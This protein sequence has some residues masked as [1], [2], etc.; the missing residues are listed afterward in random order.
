MLDEVKRVALAI[1]TAKQGE[2]VQLPS[3][4]QVR[5]GVYLLPRVWRHETFYV[6]NPLSLQQ[7]ASYFDLVILIPFNNAEETQLVTSLV[8]NRNYYL[9]VLDGDPASVWVDYNPEIVSSWLALFREADHVLV[10]CAEYLPWLRQWI[11]HDRVSYFPEPNYFATLR[12]SRR[13]QFKKWVHHFVSKQTKLKVICPFNPA[14][15]FN[16]ARQPFLSLMAFN[17]IYQNLKE[18]K[19]E[20]LIL[21]DNRTVDYLESWNLNWIQVAKPESIHDL[22][23]IY[24]AAF[25]MINLDS[26]FSVGHWIVDA[27]AFGIPVIHSG[28][29]DAGNRLFPFTQAKSFDA[30]Q[31]LEIFQLLYRD[32]KFYQQVGSY[33]EKKSR[34]YSCQNLRNLLLKL[35]GKESVPESNDKLKIA[36]N[37]DR[38][39]VD[40]GGGGQELEDVTHVLDMVFP[41]DGPER[42]KRIVHNLT[43]LPYPFESNSVD[44]VYCNHAI[45]HLTQP[46]AQRLIREVMRILKPG[47]I[48]H[49]ETPNLTKALQ[50]GSEMEDL[51]EKTPEIAWGSIVSTIYGGHSIGIG[52]EFNLHRYGY[53]HFTLSRLLKESGFEISN[54]NEEHT[55]AV[56]IE[57]RKPN[58]I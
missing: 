52:S 48:F 28:L 33:A 1:P 11:G 14:T 44:K 42:V 13:F 8:R 24:E 30:K 47:G 55:W 46:Q 35:A 41:D 25:A 51:E 7:F 27:A 49:V 26:S 32:R 53:N 6:V 34:L 37:T 21:G 20:F 50:H 54:I 43:I 57:A 5:S 15:Q 9:F 22:A 4:G 16:Q 31:I 3:D 56:I 19:L 45:E 10:H 39:V 17:L 12:H 18:T 2:I 36:Q 23:K 29:T 58:E 38:I 40:L